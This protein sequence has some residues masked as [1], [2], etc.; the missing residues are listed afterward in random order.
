[1]FNIDMSLCKMLHIHISSFNDAL[2]T[3]VINTHV[4]VRNIFKE[5]NP[6]PHVSMIRIN[7]RM[8]VHQ[9][10]SDDIWDSVRNDTKNNKNQWNVYDYK[11]QLKTVVKRNVPTPPPLLLVIDTWMNRGAVWERG[12]CVRQQSNVA[13]TYGKHQKYKRLYYA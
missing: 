6:K 1:M 9:V 8:T 2:N 10:G 3:I 13:V 11:N 5:Q 12:A 4:G 7:L